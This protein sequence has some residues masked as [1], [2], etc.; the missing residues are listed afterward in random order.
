MLVSLGI[1]ALLLVP[2]MTWLFVLFQRGQTPETGF[3]DGGQAEA[4]QHTARSP[5][6]GGAVSMRDTDRG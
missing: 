3:D 1:G 2:S 4:D 5:H 6:P